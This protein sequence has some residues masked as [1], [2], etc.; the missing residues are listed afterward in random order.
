MRDGVVSKMDSKFKVI[1]KAELG[2]DDL[3]REQSLEHFRE[4]LKKHPFLQDVRQG[5]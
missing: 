1:A 2:E 5:E 3:K 4:W